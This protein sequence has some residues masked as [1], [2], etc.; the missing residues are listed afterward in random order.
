MQV[1][2][3]R[4]RGTTRPS[5]RS[6]FPSAQL[7]KE[8]R[9]F[10]AFALEKEQ[11]EGRQGL[12][13]VGVGEGAERGSRDFALFARRRSRKGEKAVR[14][15]KG[16]K[17]GQQRNSNCNREKL[18]REHV[19]S[20]PRRCGHP[21]PMHRGFHLGAAKEASFKSPCGWIGRIWCSWGFC[22]YKVH[23]D[24]DLHHPLPE[25][26]D[27]CEMEDILLETG[28]ILSP[29][30]TMIFQD[31]DVYMLVKVKSYGSG[32]DSGEGAV[33]MAVLLRGG[34][35][36]DLD[37]ARVGPGPVRPLIVWPRPRSGP[38]RPEKIRIRQMYC[39]TVQFPALSLLAREV[40]S[41][42]VFLSRPFNE[43][44][45][46]SYLRILSPTAGATVRSLEEGNRMRSG[47]HPRCRP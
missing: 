41:P 32:F 37:R 27:L 15:G 23:K 18:Q 47:D 28:R 6:S 14:G 16:R 2:L 11:I 38:A 36:P 30:G 29:K 21:T 8:G 35:G 17:E 20:P 1:R 40:S 45:P 19:F 4:L 42:R 43:G 12:H 24:G 3:T 25:V 13:G 10:A 9:H 7:R 22:F 46:S 33:P 26:E 31:D 5:A 34:N 44:R 39:A